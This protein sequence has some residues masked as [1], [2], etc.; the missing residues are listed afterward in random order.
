LDFGEPQTWDDDLLCGITKMWGFDPERSAHI[1]FKS[2]AT[3]ERLL[4]EMNG[5]RAVCLVNVT[6]SRHADPS[7]HRTVVGYAWLVPERLDADEA[8]NPSLYNQE[9]DDD[10]G[11]VHKIGEYWFYGLRIEAAYRFDTPIPMA[12]AKQVGIPET[13][14]QGAVSYGYVEVP[15]ARQLSQFPRSPCEVY[16]PAAANF[17]R[18]GQGRPAHSIPQGDLYRKFELQ[19]WRYTYLFQF[20][21]KRSHE[22]A[23]AL[24]LLRRLHAPDAVGRLVLVK[25]GATANPEERLR[26]ISGEDGWSAFGV[27]FRL[28]ADPIDHGDQQTVAAAETNGKKKA[29]EVGY[30]V[31]GEY[32]LVPENQ[33]VEVLVAMR[34][35]P[36]MSAYQ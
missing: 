9:F 33:R 16:E 7:E 24:K 30:H 5:Q 19:E 17:R 13:R 10:S 20:D 3:R 25:V 22:G 15:A 6:A 1:A 2:R 35:R 18:Q 31:S 23:E 8:L 21:G 4:R 12:Q 27:E 34:E 14:R 11:N 32:W 36:R 29:D 28:F 26:V